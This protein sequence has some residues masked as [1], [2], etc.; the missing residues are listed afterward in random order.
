MITAEQYKELSQ[1]LDLLTDPENQPH[2]YV[3]RKGKL[4]KRITTIFSKG[5]ES[6]ELFD[7]KDFE[8]TDNSKQKEGIQ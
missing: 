7:A 6:E 8:Q 4:Y 1:L 3:D 5:E 2:Q